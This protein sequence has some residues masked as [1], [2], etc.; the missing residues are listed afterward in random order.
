MGQGKYPSVPEGEGARPRRRHSKRDAQYTIIVSLD[1]DTYQWL[2]AA[3]ERRKASA[4][5][6]KH[7]RDLV[8]TIV[9][10]A[11]RNNLV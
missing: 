9:G 11:R 8:A 4:G 7:V 10:H 6:E 1:K 3:L 5:P 2:E